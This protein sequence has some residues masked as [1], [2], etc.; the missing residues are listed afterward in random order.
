MAF[1]CQKCLGFIGVAP[2]DMTRCRCIKPSLR[3]KL[4]SSS[5]ARKVVNQKEAMSAEGRLQFDVG[6]EIMLRHRLPGETFTLEAIAQVCGVSRERIRQIERDAKRKFM[7]RLR[8]KMGMS[9]E[10]FMTS[11]FSELMVFFTQKPG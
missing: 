5:R 8:R 6:L 4:S 7:D 10:E 9:W 3:K 2:D 1:Q 11:G